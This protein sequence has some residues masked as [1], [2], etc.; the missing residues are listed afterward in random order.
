MLV[1]SAL[2]CSW[3]TQT[4]T[5]TAKRHADAYEQLATIKTKP[6]EVEEGFVDENWNFY[7]RF[8]AVKIAKM[9]KQIPADFQGVELYSED[10][11]GEF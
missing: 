9:F 7:N 5:I 2:K 6:L 10:L 11:W 1:N 4:L 3:A 8:Q